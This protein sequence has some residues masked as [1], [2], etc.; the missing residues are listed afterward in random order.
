MTT[1]TAVN[2]ADEVLTQ[3]E[4]ASE[5]NFF[6]INWTLQRQVSK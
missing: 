5:K 4:A 1:Q 6:P 3:I 2:N